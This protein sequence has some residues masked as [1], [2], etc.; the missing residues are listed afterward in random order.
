MLSASS[1]RR[2]GGAIFNA[3]GNIFDNRPV[4]RVFACG[5]IVAVSA[6][7]G[8]REPH[9]FIHGS[10]QETWAAP[11]GVVHARHFLVFI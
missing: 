9:T 6:D 4:V 10:E 7:R 8:D 11:R 1:G 5:V 3:S 2:V